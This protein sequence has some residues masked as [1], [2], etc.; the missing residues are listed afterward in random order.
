MGSNGK[1]AKGSRAEVALRHR[2]NAGRVAVRNQIGL[3]RGQFGNVASEWKGDDTRVT[4]ADFAISE[5]MFHE[6]RASFPDDDFCSE[7]G[8]PPDEMN[9]LEAPYAWV[10]DPIDGTNNYFLGLPHCAISLAIL[11]EGV[12]V[13]GFVYDHARDRLIEGG[14]GL[15]L[16]ED[17]TRVNYTPEPLDPRYSI[18]AVSFPVLAED[19]VRVRPW[20]EVYRCR[21][22]GSA[23][24]HLAYAAIGKVD[25][26]M[27][28]KVRV[29]DMA[30][31]YALILGGGGMFHFDGPSPFPMTVFGANMPTLR[32]WAGSK[33]FCEMITDCFQG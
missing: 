31:G 13:Y 33:Y 21:A 1:L 6:L 7:E 18:A 19:L 3:F 22:L 29:W 16:T 28:F 30:A 2:I 14:P 25:G 24:L 17:G 5:K 10:L 11:F 12:P 32:Y 15:G 27:D 20:M 26:C 8:N 4:F 9:P 23:T